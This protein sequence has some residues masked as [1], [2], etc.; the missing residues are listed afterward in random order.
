MNLRMSVLL[1]LNFRFTEFSELQGQQPG[2]SEKLR[3]VVDA[4]L[5]LRS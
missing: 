1:D 2:I 5:A 3:C 4:F